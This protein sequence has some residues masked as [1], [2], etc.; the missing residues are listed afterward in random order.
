MGKYAPTFLH[1]IRRGQL[2]EIPFIRMGKIKKEDKCVGRG[3]EDKEE[4]ESKRV[5]FGMPYAN[6]EK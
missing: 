4:I 2:G 6:K 5:K 3:K 1:L